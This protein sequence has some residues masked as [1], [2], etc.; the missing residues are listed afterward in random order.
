MGH[1]PSLWEATSIKSWSNFSKVVHGSRRG[2]RGTTFFH[3]ESGF[4]ADGRDLVVRYKMAMTPYDLFLGFRIHLVGRDDD[5]LLNPGV[6]KGM[7]N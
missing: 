3:A 4:E 2:R 1:I 5:A 7:L 6:Q